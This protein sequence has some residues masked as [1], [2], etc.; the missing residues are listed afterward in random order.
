MKLHNLT[1]VSYTN[2]TMHSHATCFFHYK[3]KRFQLEMLCLKTIQGVRTRL[4]LILLFHN[5]IFYQNLFASKS[6]YE[7]FT[8]FISTINEQT[9]GGIISSFLYLP[10]SLRTMCK[11]I[12]YGSIISNIVGINNLNKVNTKDC[13]MFDYNRR[14]S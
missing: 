5:D 13:A 12:L 11:Q 9:Y 2:A 7:Q 3:F 10:C 4:W 6:R 8:R 14:I 1:F